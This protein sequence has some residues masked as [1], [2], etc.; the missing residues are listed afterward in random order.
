MPLSEIVPAEINIERREEVGEK[1]EV[2]K[3][4]AQ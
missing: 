3:K 2:N 1:N 4:N